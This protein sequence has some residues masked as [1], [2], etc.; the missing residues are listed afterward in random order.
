MALGYRAGQGLSA[1]D[2]RQQRGT[3]CE[4]GDKS[5]AIA[6]GFALYYVAGKCASRR[7]SE[8]KVIPGF[9]PAPAYFVSAFKTTV[10][11][12]SPPIWR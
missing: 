10:F 8:R 4:T 12:S 2:I 5:G 1:G 9:D 7:A 6:G 3:S 11:R